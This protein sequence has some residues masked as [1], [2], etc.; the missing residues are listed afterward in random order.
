MTAGPQA[1]VLTGVYGVGKSTT[2]AQIADLLEARG[3]RFAALDLDWLSWAWS[4]DNTHD[5]PLDLLMLEHLD[6]LVRN[7]LRR[8]N[9][10]FILAGSVM[11]TAG[12]DAI[13]ETMAMPTRLVRLTASLPTIRDRLGHEPT[14]G[15]EHD[16]ARTERWLAD[17]PG[18]VP[19]P[20]LEIANEGS[21]VE[22]AN[23]ILAWSGWVDEG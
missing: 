22:T 19:T 21:I 11:T 5:D 9:D 8:G 18:D 10:R 16:L 4:E 6:L 12:W 7:L 2:A 15:R 17:P 1:I 23:A 3:A 13:R 14:T 20:D